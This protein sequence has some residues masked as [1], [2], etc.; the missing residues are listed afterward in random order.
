MD[1]E[2]LLEVW[3]Q[4]EPTVVELKPGELRKLDN[5]RIVEKTEDGKIVIYEVVDYEQD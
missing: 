1:K 2:E 3:K 4:I 5:K